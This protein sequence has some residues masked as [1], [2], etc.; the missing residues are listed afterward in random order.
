MRYGPMKRKLRRG[1]S[2]GRAAQV[3]RMRF[4]RTRRMTGAVPPVHRFKEWCQ[5]QDIVIGPS[6]SNA[7]VISFKLSD[8]TNSGSFTTLFDLYKITG[9]KLRIV[10]T[11]NTNQVNNPLYTGGTGDFTTQTA[12]PMFYIAPN[13]DPAVPAPTSV[14]DILNDDYCKIL[15][16]TRPFDLYLKNPKALMKSYNQDGSENGNIFLQLN[17]SSKAL[18]P[19]LSTGGNLAKVDQ[20]SYPHYGY[21]WYSDGN[22]SLEAPQTFHVFVK[23]Y[24][25]FKE[26]D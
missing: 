13:H 5:L 26:Q 19:W 10:P 2:A 11:W 12:L 20:S 21:R 22:F 9:V 24:V 3:R 25:S 14:A 15:R 17:S 7:G 23:Y 18:Q 8:L 1:Q 16:P 6:Q 4:A